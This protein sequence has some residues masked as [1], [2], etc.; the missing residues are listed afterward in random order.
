MEARE[1]WRVPMIAASLPGTVSCNPV[2][3]VGRM[4]AVSEFS[5]AL[6]NAKMS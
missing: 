2:S 4:N 3:L 5:K 6:R 1:S